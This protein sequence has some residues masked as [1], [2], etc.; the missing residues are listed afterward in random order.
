MN[1]CFEIKKAHVIA[2]IH[3]GTEEK[4]KIININ[5]KRIRLKACNIP[6][7]A[8]DTFPYPL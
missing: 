3:Y 5:L 6:L 7:N 8:T 2:S 1:Y 4:V